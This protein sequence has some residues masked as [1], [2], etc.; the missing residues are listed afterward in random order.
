[1]AKRALSREVG[2]FSLR[3]RRTRGREKISYAG[4]RVPPEVI[5]QAIWLYLRFTMSFQRLLG[6]K[7]A[8]D[9]HNRAVSDRVV[10]I[11]R[12][13]SVAEAGERRTLVPANE[14]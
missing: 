2:L 7:A 4:Y 12:Y 5:H 1:M 6:G 11:A 10:R 9:R 14:A 8:R 3:K 13:D